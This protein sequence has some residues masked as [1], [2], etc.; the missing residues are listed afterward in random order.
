M[1]IHEWY[2]SLQNH[3]N[4]SYYRLTSREK[5]VV[6][7]HAKIYSI[8]YIALLL[9]T[10]SRE[11]QNHPILD[12]PQHQRFALVNQFHELFFPPKK[13]FS[14]SANFA[15]VNCRGY[16]LQKSLT[17]S[18]LPLRWLKSKRIKNLYLKK[19]PWYFFQMVQELHWPYHGL[20]MAVAIWMLVDK[21]LLET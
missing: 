2:F 16:D 10:K 17:A 7:Y 21:R 14:M 5:D 19:N 18:K 12:W 4:T 1:Y 6:E 9:E 13:G 20:T 3:A 8:T 11:I 15:F